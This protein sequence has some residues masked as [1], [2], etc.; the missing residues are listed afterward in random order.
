MDSMQSSFAMTQRAQP[1]L[2]RDGP[3]VS[4]TYEGRFMVTSCGCLG[5]SKDRF[6]LVDCGGK[7]LARRGSTLTMLWV[8]AMSV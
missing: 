1:E 5:R 3:T 4:R 7:S 6:L 8:E 2:W